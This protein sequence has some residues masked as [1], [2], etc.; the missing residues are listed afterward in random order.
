MKMNIIIQGCFIHLQSHWLNQENLVRNGIQWKL[1]W[2][3]QEQFVTVN[4]VKVTD[5]T[6]VIL[7]LNG[8]LIL[9]LYAVHVLIPAIWVFRIMV[10]QDVVFFQGNCCETI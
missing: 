3:V 8:N 6:K 2:T 4:G 7:F 9:N 1:L 10:K 5:Y